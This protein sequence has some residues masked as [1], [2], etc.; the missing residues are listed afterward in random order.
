[1][2]NLLIS[3]FLI[4]CFLGGDTSGGFI[5]LLF[6]WMLFSEVTL[7]PIPP[8]KRAT[9]VH[10]FVFTIIFFGDDGSNWLIKLGVMVTSC[11]LICYLGILYFSNIGGTSFSFATYLLSL[12]D[13]ESLVIS[14][15]S[16]S[17]L[18]CF[19]YYLVLLNHYALE[20]LFFCVFSII[21]I[22]Q[23]ISSFFNLLTWCNFITWWCFFFW[24]WANNM[25][26]HDDLFLELLQKNYWLQTPVKHL[27][28]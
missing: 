26:R 8:E 13:S 7:A 21:P 17:S 2:I 3:W 4:G 27:I 6:L 28:V 12:D 14:S 11:V 9:S 1:M 20:G 16:K 19:Y 24:K 15:L 18:T 25:R 10:I 5:F 22:I 23:Q